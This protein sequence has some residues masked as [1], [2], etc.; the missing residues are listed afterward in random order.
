ML[1][2]R[3]SQDKVRDLIWK[4]LKAGVMKG[5]R[6][7]QSIAGTPQGGILSPLLANI[8]L[9][10]LDQEVKSFTEET[11]PGKGH[12]TYVRYADD[13]LLLTSGSRGEADEKRQWVEDYVEEELN[14]TLNEEKTSV[15]HAED[16]GIEFLGYQIEPA[17]PT[18]GGGSYM[19]IPRDAVRDVKSAIRRQC[20]E[21]A[22][23]DV[24]ARSR[25]RGLNYVLRG[26]AGYY[27]YATHTAE[28]FSE[29]DSF[30][31]Q[32]LSHWLAKKYRCTRKAFFSR[33][34]VESSPIKVNGARM[35]Y[36]QSMTDAKW[37]EPKEK[38]HPYFDGTAKRTEPTATYQFFVEE[39]AAD[40]RDLRWK[41]F[42]RDDFTCQ[43]CGADVG[44][45]GSG[46]LHHLEYSGEMVDAE[47]LCTSCHA[48]KDPHRHV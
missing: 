28:V 47:T 32:N 30:A 22:S 46:E 23:T 41:V 39:H 31:W 36:I 43:E 37:T 21:E 1:A 2:K 20:G 27:K 40:H 48:E 29:V 17:H 8:Y 18:D 34:G 7:K 15:A 5:D 45:Q 25:I 38:S 24:S 35:A 16:G 3:I 42:Q 4:F 9:D 13:F 11:S 12:W 19:K 10:S 14:L 44:W 26:W 6:R 33:K